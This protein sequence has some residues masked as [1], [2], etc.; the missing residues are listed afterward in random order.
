MTTPHPSTSCPV[1]HEDRQILIVNKPQGVLSHP[2]PKAAKPQRAAF[3]G[4]YDAD[5]RCFTTPGG[6][7]YLIHRLDQDTSGVLLAAKDEKNA[8]TLREAFEAEEV[9]KTYLA[10]GCGG[11]LKPEGVWLDHLVTEHARHQVRTA[12]RRGPRPNAELRYRLLHYSAAHRLSLLEIDLITGKT[13]QIRV[14]AAS[15]HV[16]LAG[17]DVYGSF[18]HNRA[19]KKSLGIR[20]L[21]LHAHQIAFKHPASGQPMRI[22]APLPEDLLA[23]LAA[24]RI[25]MHQ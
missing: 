1:L 4:R 9:R 16:A 12:V 19:L 2:N 22:I 14:Q 5:R 20:R 7:V 13:H 23:V 18:D 3:E 6:P 21:F 10:L 17:D 11:G 24:A 8:D 25:P 15:R